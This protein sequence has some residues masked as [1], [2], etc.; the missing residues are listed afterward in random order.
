[1]STS[2]LNKTEFQTVIEA[3]EKIKKNRI[4]LFKGIIS[5]FYVSGIIGLSIPIVR[6]YFQ[7]MTPFTLILSLGILLLFHSGWNKSF[8][9]F[10]VL[11]IILGFGSE[12]MGI[13]T[14]FP[15]GDYEYGET[16]G[17]KLFEVPLVI[18]VNWLLLV[19]LTGNLFSSKIKH[20]G[21]AAGLAALLMVAVDFLIEPVAV[22]LDFWSWAGD[23]IPLSNYFGWL[24]V[25]FIIQ[26]L[27]RKFN[28]LKENMISSYLLINLVT[29]FAILNFIS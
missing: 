28:F 8:G 2:Q 9:V 1:M 7:M 25:S 12:V 13:H 20:D 29:F 23:I 6:P 21:L 26:I 10:A 14:G 5:A 15:F 27:Y 22:N 16:L 3:I 19:Y 18:G 17:F 11:A 24:G 4:K